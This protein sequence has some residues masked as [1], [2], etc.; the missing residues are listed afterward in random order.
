MQEKSATPTPLT[1]YRSLAAGVRA[2]TGG[3][4]VVVRRRRETAATPRAARG[5]RDE[6]RERARRRRAAH[7][8][9][10][11]SRRPLLR[12]APTAIVQVG[13]G[14]C[15]GCERSRRRKTAPSGVFFLQ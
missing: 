5:A 13:D 7:A 10:A 14:A 4:A 15:I 6:R 12:T 9:T 11:G 3:V 1:R 8:S 2:R